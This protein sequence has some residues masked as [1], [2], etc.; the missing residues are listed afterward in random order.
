M[1]LNI[2]CGA[3]SINLYYSISRIYSDKFR[4]QLLRKP[5]R[6]AITRIRIS[7]V[8]TS[9]CLEAIQ[10]GNGFITLAYST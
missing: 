4:T 2:L 3:I 1:C 8:F 5:Y 6:V 10:Y 9:E 7:V